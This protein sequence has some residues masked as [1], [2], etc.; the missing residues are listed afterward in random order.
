MSR[1]TR[2]FL[3]ACVGV[4]SLLSATAAAASTGMPQPSITKQLVGVPCSV[5]VYGLAFING[6]TPSMSYGGGVSC[7]GGVGQK[8]VNVVPEVGKAVNGQQHWYVIGGIGLYQGPTP[9]NPLRVSGTTSFVAGHVYRLLV[10]GGVT[11][12]DGRTSSMTICSGCAPSTSPLP[13]LRVTGYDRNEPFP[14]R[15]VPIK[16]IAGLSCSVTEF[17]PVFKIVNLTYVDPRH[18]VRRPLPGLNLLESLRLGQQQVR[19]QDRLVHD[20]GFVPEQQTDRNQ[21]GLSHDRSNRVPGSRIS[22]QG[23]SHSQVRDLER[24]D[25]QIGHRLR[26]RGSPVAARP[27]GT[28][29]SEPG[30]RAFVGAELRRRQDRLGEAG[31]VPAQDRQTVARLDARL[32]Q[33]A[34]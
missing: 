16:G 21:P 28:R 9:V 18:T 11:L 10:Y 26:G 33:P 15:T 23:L 5:T 22:N 3:L 7:A 30:R 20:R 17:G 8:T 6:G 14:P 4:G 24:R 31:V 19:R 1:S 32:V 27:T 34:G 29:C 12:P 25:H 13:T 2:S